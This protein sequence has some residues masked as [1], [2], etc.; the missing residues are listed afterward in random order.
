MR[1]AWRKNMASRSMI[2][3]ARLRLG[4]YVI[5][6][7]DMTGAGMF[8]IKVRDTGKGYPR[9]TSEKSVRAFTG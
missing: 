4:G 5:L 2:Y 9:G 6:S 3:R 1:R 8:R 7:C